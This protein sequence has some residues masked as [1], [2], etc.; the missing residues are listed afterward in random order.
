VRALSIA[1]LLVLALAIAV[2]VQIVGT[3]LVFA[4]LVAPGAS[5]LQLTARPMRGL[6]LSIALSLAFTWL[7]LAIAYFTIYPIGF[8]ITTFAFASYALIRLLRALP[9]L[10]PRRTGWVVDNA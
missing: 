1:F 7:G 3:L 6:A 9:E 10:R 4:L 2:T 8:F 5:A